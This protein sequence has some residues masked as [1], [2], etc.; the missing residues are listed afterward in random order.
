MGDTTHGKS[1][2]NRAVAAWLGT[3]RLWLH[4]GRLELPMADGTMLVV[5]S[6][7]GGEW[8]PLLRDAPA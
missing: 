2:H 5:D 1:A 6:E 4:A 7:P 8:A 3:S